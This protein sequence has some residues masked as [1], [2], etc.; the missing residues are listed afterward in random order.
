[1][2]KLFCCLQNVELKLH[3]FSIANFG[4][5]FD[6]FPYS[7]NDDVQRHIVHNFCSEMSKKSIVV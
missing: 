7:C 5:V 4:K 2:L 6:F 1:M 3:N